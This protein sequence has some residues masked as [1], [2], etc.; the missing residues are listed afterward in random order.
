MK[1]TVDLKNV[2]E[3]VPLAFICSMGLCTW[4]L[5][6]SSLRIIGIAALKLI[7]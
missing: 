1:W 5:E 7:C 3:F 2:F 6:D 4:A